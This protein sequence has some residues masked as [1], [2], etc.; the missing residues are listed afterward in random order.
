MLAAMVASTAM[1]LATA[2]RADGPGVAFSASRPGGALPEGWQ[3]KPVVSGRTLTRYTL[4][5]EQGT[6]VLEADATGAASGL[7]HAGDFDLAATPVVQWRWK[8]AGPIPNADNR[9]AKREDAPARL[10]FFFD[11]ES[12]NLSI[13]ERAGMAISG[14][15]RRQAAL[16]H[17]D[18]YLDQQRPGGHGHRQSAYQPGADDC[19]GRRGR[20]RQMAEAAPQCECGLPEGFSARHPESCWVMA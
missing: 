13:G 20:C 4:V 6:T 7:I 9:E 8:V 14:R 11:G 5:A 12:S 15:G 16:R 2:A 3:N 10:V 17:A 19:G 18:V 1:T